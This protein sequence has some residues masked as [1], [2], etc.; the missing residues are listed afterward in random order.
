MNPVEGWPPGPPGSGL[1]SWNDP[2]KLR[3]L[4]GALPY[5]PPASADP[6]RKPDE[7][8]RSVS[9]GAQTQGPASGV[10]V[11]IPAGVKT[12]TG[13]IATDTHDAVKVLRAAVELGAKQLWIGPATAAYLGLPEFFVVPT[14]AEPHRYGIPHPWL[15]P[16]LQ[17]WPASTS[18]AGLAPWLVLGTPDR[19]LDVVLPSWDHSSPW[20]AAGTAGELLQALELYAELVGIRWRRGAGSTGLALMRH[21]HSG[22]GAVKLPE[23]HL[24]PPALEVGSQARGS[25]IAP[26]LPAGGYL[27]A[28]DVNGMYLAACS[29]AELGFGEPVHL[30]APGNGIGGAGYWLATVATP[31]KQGA[32]PFKADGTPRWY[33]APAMQLLEE[34]HAQARVAGAWMYPESRRWLEPWYARLRDART[35]LLAANTPAALLALAALKQTYAFTLGRLAGSWLGEGDPTFRPDWR[36]VVMDRAR[37]NMHRHLSRVKA[38][39]VA[40]DADLVV[41]PSKIADPAGAAAELG[42]ELDLQQVGKWKPAGSCSAKDARAAIAGKKG[43]AAQRAL[44]EVLR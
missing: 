36:H 9:S 38:T 43:T 7:P 18:N 17:T 6:G 24:A 40:L 4:P 41:Y 8:T 22:P 26:R 34:F 37:A 23:P 21:V 44:L 28:Y 14:S 19:Y 27:Q 35:A 10:A 12:S 16:A 11:L 2:T 20:R 39:P 29:S 1:A 5:V 15:A 13:W 30:E 25:W 42:L 32:L 33:T 3:G 31:T